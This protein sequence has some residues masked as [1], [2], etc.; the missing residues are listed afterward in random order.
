GL[1]QNQNGVK[2]SLFSRNTDKNKQNTLSLIEMMTAKI[3]QSPDNPALIFQRAKLYLKI[4][5]PESALNDCIAAARL[6]KRYIKK[7]KLLCGRYHPILCEKFMSAVFY[8]I[9]TDQPK[10]FIRKKE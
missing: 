2:M 4:Q 5:E 7:G 6:D 9:N 10:P 3:E 1:S 8:V